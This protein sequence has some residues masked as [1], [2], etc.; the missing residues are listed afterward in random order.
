[1]NGVGIGE[2]WCHLFAKCVLKVTG[3]DDTHACRDDE[4]CTVFK[5][6]ID[7]AVNGVQSI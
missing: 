4:L 5:E 2:T 3:Y 7:R 1:M 6:G